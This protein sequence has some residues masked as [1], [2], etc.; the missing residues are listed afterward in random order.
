MKVGN[1]VSIV[2]ITTRLRTGQTGIRIPAGARVF[3]ILQ[4]V[5]TGS[6]ALKTTCCTGTGGSFTE[7]KVAGG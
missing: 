2:S 4:N 6:E 1:C 5:Q 3:Y 7:Y